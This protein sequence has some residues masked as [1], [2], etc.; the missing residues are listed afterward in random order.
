MLW[1]RQPA[2]HHFRRGGIAAPQ[3][4]GKERPVIAL[5]CQAITRRRTVRAGMTEEVVY[6]HV[7]AMGLGGRDQS[8]IRHQRGQPMLFP[9]LVDQLDGLRF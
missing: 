4:L 6:G 3:I 9:F 2:L 8:S 5:A 1:T 7:L